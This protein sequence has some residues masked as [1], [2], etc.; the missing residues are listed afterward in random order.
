MIRS[1]SF[2]ALR[3]PISS[4]MHACGRVGVMTEPGQ[5]TL[6][7]RFLQS[8]LPPDHKQQQHLKR[9]LS[10]SSR[11]R[12]DQIRSAGAPG[13]PCA[14]HSSSTTAKRRRSLF[15]VMSGHKLMP[16]LYRPPQT[17]PQPERAWFPSASVVPRRRPRTRPK[18][19][20]SSWIILSK[21][22]GMVK[23]AVHSRFLF[24]GF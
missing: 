20:P 19:Q 22:V 11:R 10:Q 15:P 9:L 1:F 7:Q 24:G 5:L 18:S 12:F 21:L 23:N 2:S 3:T 8:A 6:F 13:R 14:K 17:A 16:Q 4:R